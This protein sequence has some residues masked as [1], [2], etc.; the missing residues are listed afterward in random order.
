MTTRKQGSTYPIT[1][2]LRDLNGPRNLT[3]S[4]VTLSMRDAHTAVVKINNAAVTVTSPSNGAFT[5]SIQATDVDTG[6]EYQV[7]MKEVR[8]DGTIWKYPSDGYEPLT[9]QQSFS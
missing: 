8:S 5:Y 7:E 6:S 2:T 9:I 3:G 1:G 4:T